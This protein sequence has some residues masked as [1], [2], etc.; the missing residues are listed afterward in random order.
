MDGLGNA[1]TTNSGG[2]AFWMFY[3]ALPF[4]L[5]QIARDITVVAMKMYNKIPLRDVVYPLIQFFFT[6]S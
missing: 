2:S 6:N 5:S 3:Y 1:A 4:V